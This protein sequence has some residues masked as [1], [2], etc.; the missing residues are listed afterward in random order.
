VST[1]YY[2]RAVHRDLDNA[3]SKGTGGVLQRYK[4]LESFKIYLHALTRGCIATDQRIESVGLLLASFAGNQGNI[5][6]TE[7][8]GRE[9]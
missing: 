5:G 2:F 8:G 7:N 1:P 3:I 9:W 4:S 6:N